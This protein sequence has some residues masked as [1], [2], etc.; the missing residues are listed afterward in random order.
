MDAEVEAILAFLSQE[1]DTA[2]LRKMTDAEEA[3]LEYL[4][5]VLLMAGEITEEPN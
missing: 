1:S 2:L 5:T 4:E 3:R